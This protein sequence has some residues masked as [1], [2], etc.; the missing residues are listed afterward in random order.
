[1]SDQPAG[2]VANWSGTAFEL[3]LGVQ[4]CVYMLVGDP[5]REAFFQKVRQAL[6]QMGAE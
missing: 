1:V 2:G 5:D 4:F 3:R 6:S